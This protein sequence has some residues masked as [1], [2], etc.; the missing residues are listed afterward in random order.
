MSTLTRRDKWIPW[1]FVAFFSVLALVDGVMVT[2]AVRTQTGVVTDHPYEKGL[3]YNRVL[4][5][6]NAQK[7]LG[8]KGAVSYE[9]GALRFRLTDKNGALLKP[10]A[11]TAQIK[12]PT[13]AS[14]DFTVTLVDG[15]ARFR[16]PQP[17]LWDVHIFATIGDIPYQQTQRM[18]IP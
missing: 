10:Q 5:A 16:F 8:W 15:S 13:Q 7:S 9:G 11:I 6:A 17:G 18:V 2:L 4:D 12:R 1:Y 14:M 3:A